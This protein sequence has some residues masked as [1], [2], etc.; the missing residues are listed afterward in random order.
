[1]DF[2]FFMTHYM[3]INDIMPIVIGY[4]DYS[5]KKINFL[6]K[7]EGKQF[8]HSGNWW[9]IDP[10]KRTK[11][12]ILEN[13]EKMYIEGKTVGFMS[14]NVPASL[15]RVDYWNISERNR[16]K[17]ILKCL[18]N[19][20]WVLKNKAVKTPIYC[21]IEVTTYD[22]SIKWFKKAMDEGHGAFCRGIAEFLRYPKYRKE[23]LKRIIEI[24]IAARKVLEN[25][26]FHLSGT[27]S[28]FL[29]PIFAYLGATSL[30]GSTPITSALA[31]GT[32]YDQTGKGVKAGSIKSWN[33]K[34]NVC[35]NHGEREIIKLFNEDSHFRVLHNIEMW[36][37]KMNEI[38]SYKNR[39][40]LK[41]M[42]INSSE[43]GESKYLIR[44]WEEVKNIMK[45]FE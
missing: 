22:E 35:T 16:E 33:C 38:R 6:K 43:I 1:M 25:L 10:A 15:E 40:E 19:A 32:L 9:R 11:E 34:C 3:K 5:L 17:S 31:R 44:V 8:I 12:K 13:Q 14:M 4:E 21:S 30:D 42:I 2:D 28:L 7:Y 23:G 37:N 29:M 18:E 20:N 45:K 39:E 24:T 36:K 27:A 26:P 41:E